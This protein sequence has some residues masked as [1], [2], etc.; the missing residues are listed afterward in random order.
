MKL[1][2]CPFCGGDAQL[3][4]ICG[5]VR[6]DDDDLLYVMVQCRDCCAATA[7]LPFARFGDGA[8]PEEAEAA[9]VVVHLWNTRHPQE[10]G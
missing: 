5:S 7:Y 8:I 4:D 9:S 3:F 10:G 1:K 2:P 6:C